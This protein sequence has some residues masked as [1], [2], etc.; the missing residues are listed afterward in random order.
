MYSV[1]RGATVDRRAYKGVYVLMESVKPSPDRVNITPITPTDLTEPEVTGGYLFKRDRP[2]D[3]ED[4]LDAGTAGGRFWFEEPLVWVDPSEEVVAPEQAR[5]LGGAVDA[6]ADALADGQPYS[7]Q[8][9][10]DAWIDHH[11]L[12]TFPK[13]PDAFRLSGYLY[14]DRDGPIVAGPVWDM[15]RTMGCADDDRAT[16]PTWWDATNQTSDTTPLFTFGWYEPMFADPQFSARYWARW[17]EVIDDTLGTEH[18]DEVIDEMAAEL[19]EAA[20]RN[21]QRWNENPPRNGGFDGEVAI[22]KDW[23]AQ[24]HDWIEAC[25]ALP[26][27]S[28]CR[29]D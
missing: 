27:P 22:L 19:S 11:I 15:D 9:D 24:R 6:F 2:G 21:F 16:Y 8:I 13:N 5:Y 18:V 29:G 7:D 14:K 17:H 20:P 10:V 25:L 1:G 28:A 4:G 3:G 26:D 12:N 23:L